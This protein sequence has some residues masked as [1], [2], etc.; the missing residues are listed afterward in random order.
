MAE[1]KQEMGSPCSPAGEMTESDGGSSL[2]SSGYGSQPNMAIEHHT[3]RLDGRF[4]VLCPFIVDVF[5]PLS[6][7]CMVVSSS[8]S[9]R[10]FLL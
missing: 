9:V 3:S 7:Y 6:L 2:G 1:L 5:I 4:E 8:L 10:R